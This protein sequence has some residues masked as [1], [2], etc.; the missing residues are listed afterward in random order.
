MASIGIAVAT[1][2][3]NLP[4]ATMVII[5]ILVPMLMISGAWSPPEAMHP[6]IKYISL[7]SPMRYFLDF[8][9]TPIAIWK[10]TFLRKLEPCLDILNLLYTYQ[11]VLLL[12]ACQHIL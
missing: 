12:G 3:D 8:F 5:A 2:V 7:L 1:M 10:R 11:I 4:Q 9:T 6:V